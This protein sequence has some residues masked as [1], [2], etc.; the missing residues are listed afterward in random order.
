MR[1]KS[2]YDG[3]RITSLSNLI[4]RGDT[5]IDIRDYLDISD[6]EVFYAGFFKMPNFVRD[7][8]G[9]VFHNMYYYS[10]NEDSTSTIIDRTYN[11]GYRLNIM[12]R[13]GVDIL[14]SDTSEI[15]DIVLSLNTDP[16]INNLEDLRYT[17]KYISINI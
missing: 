12:I 14:Y 10:T 2:Q 4:H 7:S 9:Q 11:E 17:C 5:N 13:G 6:L 1:V 16:N 15:A 3:G 8:I